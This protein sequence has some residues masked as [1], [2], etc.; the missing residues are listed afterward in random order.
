M[1]KPMGP[2][3]ATARAIR[4]CCR[5]RHLTAALN[6]QLRFSPN[7]LA[8]RDLLARGGLGALVDVD[9]RIV[10]DRVRVHGVIELY[11]G[12]P[13]IIVEDSKQIDMAE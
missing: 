1:Q 11:R 13:E 5:D 8:L 4:A 12:K 6:F 9:V 10:I 2:D 3:L 7:V